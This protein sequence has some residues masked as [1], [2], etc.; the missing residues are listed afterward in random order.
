M[1]KTPSL[2]TIIL[3]GWLG[4]MFATA[5]AALIKPLQLAVA[6]ILCHAPYSHGVVEI[7]S[8][9]YGATSGY[10]TSLRCA[11]AQHQEHATSLIAVIGLLWLY[12]WVGA[13]AIRGEY[14]WGKV[15]ITKGVDSYWR[16]RLPPQPARSRP[17]ATPRS[18][19]ATTATSPAVGPVTRAAPVFGGGRSDPVDQLARLADLRDRGVL[20]GEEFASEK[21]RILRS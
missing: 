19:L 16:R 18:L 21:A 2:W 13:L 14:Y 7:H 5:V 10:S 17:T 20:T 1:Q 4:F 12:G 8:Y 11:N 6:P 15:A 3:T 9:S